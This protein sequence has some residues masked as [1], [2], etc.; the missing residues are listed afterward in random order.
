MHHFQTNR[1]IRTSV[2]A[3]LDVVNMEFRHEM[4]TLS[5]WMAFRS[6]PTHLKQQVMMYFSY[7]SR[8]QHGMLDH[9]ILEELPPYL[10]KKLAVHNNDMLA[11]ISEDE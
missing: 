10:S 2:L 3:N 9:F 6:V 4:D 11:K 7:L 8:S 5:H 1:W